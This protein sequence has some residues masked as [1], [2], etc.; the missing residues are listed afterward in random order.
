MKLRLRFLAGA[1]APVMTVAG[2]AL[3]D[4]SGSRGDHMGDY[5]M[6]G[7]GWF[8]GPMVMLIF[9]VALVLIVILIVRWLLPGGTG[10]G[11]AG[12]GGS[13]MLILAERYARGE[14]DKAE[15]EQKKRDLA[16]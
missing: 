1:L 8:M 13:A 10:A 14:I 7:G 4:Q 9:F 11:Q 12:L 2:P 16:G 6:W 5:M 3:A 15:F